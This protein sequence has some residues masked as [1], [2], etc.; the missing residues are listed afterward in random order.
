MTNESTNRKKLIKDEIER[1]QKRQRIFW[2]L[3]QSER[4]NELWRELARTE[5][6]KIA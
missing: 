3:R 5:N 4:I 6:Q 2:T 1:L